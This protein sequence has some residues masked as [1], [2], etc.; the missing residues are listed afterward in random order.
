[1]DG[2][3]FEGFHRG[4]SNTPK[5]LRFVKGSLQIVLPEVDSRLMHLVIP[6]I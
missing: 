5:S 6:E 3:S 2:P 4:L 1:M